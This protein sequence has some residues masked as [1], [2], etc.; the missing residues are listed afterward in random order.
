MLT[1]VYINKFYADKPINHKNRQQIVKR[2][3]GQ[4]FKI[5]KTLG[6]AKQFNNTTIRINHEK[7]KEFNLNDILSYI[8]K[9]SE[10]AR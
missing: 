7:L 6:I 4:I 5:L 8:I 3:I 1:G 2:K 10:I 9:D